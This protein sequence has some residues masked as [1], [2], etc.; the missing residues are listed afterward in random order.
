MGNKKEKEMENLYC[1][2]FDDITG[3]ITKIVIKDYKI[4]KINNYNRIG[5]KFYSK[6]I[7][8]S[9]NYYFVENSKLD[10]FVSNK[11]YTFKDDIDMVRRTIRKTLEEKTEEYYRLYTRSNSLLK[12]FNKRELEE[13][14]G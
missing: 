9:A 4:K 14:N 13:K 5:Y 10:R 6:E 8:K 12:T 11:I 1:F 2:K 3:E 7:N